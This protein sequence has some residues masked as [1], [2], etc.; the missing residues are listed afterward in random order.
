MIKR[1]FC[2]RIHV[3]NRSK[4]QIG[5]RHVEF[6]VSIYNALYKIYLGDFETFLR[7]IRPG[8]VVQDQNNML[9]NA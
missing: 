8:N 9:H 5:L 1:I 2:A 7:Y 6:K 3:Y 4:F